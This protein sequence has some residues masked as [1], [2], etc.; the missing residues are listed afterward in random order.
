MLLTELATNLS[1]Y[2][3]ESSGAEDSYHDRCMP[4]YNNANHQN[5]AP[6]H[7]NYRID[8]RQHAYGGGHGHDSGQE[9]A[10]PGQFED[11]SGHRHGPVNSHDGEELDYRGNTVYDAR[12]DM[13]MGHEDSKHGFVHGD[14]RQGR[15]G[16]S[17]HVDPGFNQGEHDWQEEYQ[18]PGFSSFG[19]HYPPH[20]ADPRSHY[21]ESAYHRDLPRNQP[22]P[23]QRNPEFNRSDMRHYSSD[24]PPSKYSNSRRRR[25]S[26]EKK[27][28]L[29]QIKRSRMEGSEHRSSPGSHHSNHQSSSVDYHHP[30]STPE[31]YK[32]PKDTTFGSSKKPLLNRLG[33]FSDEVVDMKPFSDAT[34]SKEVNMLHRLGPMNTVHSRLGPQQESPLLPD[35]RT[36]L[37]GRGKLSAESEGSTSS[38][39]MPVPLFPSSDLPSAKPLLKANSKV[40]LFP[41]SELPSAKS[42]LKV[43]SKEMTPHVP[44]CRS[45]PDGPGTKGTAKAPLVE[46]AKTSTSTVQL[47]AKRPVSISSS[48]APKKII[49]RK[50]KVSQSPVETTPT[51]PSATNITSEHSPSSQNPPNQLLRTSQLQQ[52]GATDNLRKNQ[53]GVGV[54]S[55][56]DRRLP[57]QKQSSI[58]DGQQQSTHGTTPRQQLQQLRAATDP[59]P[60]PSLDPRRHQQ[61]HSLSSTDPRQRQQTRIGDGNRLPTTATVVKDLGMGVQESDSDK[62]SDC[63]L[64]IDEGAC[65]SNDD[66]TVVHPVEPKEH[67][68][69]VTPGVG[70][71]GV[72]DKTRLDKTTLRISA[73]ELDSTLMKQLFAE[74]NLLQRLYDSLKILIRFLNGKDFWHQAF[75]GRIH[76]LFSS[77]SIGSAPSPAKLKDQFKLELIHLKQRCG[78]DVRMWQE[79]IRK[80]SSLSATFPK[81]K[82][83]LDVKGYSD[84]VLVVDKPSG[85]E[86]IV[87]SDDDSSDCAEKRGVPCKIRSKSKLDNVLVVKNMVSNVPV[88][89]SGVPLVVSSMQSV[90][91]TASSTSVPIVTSSVKNVPKGVE[92]SVSS[93]RGVGIREVGIGVAVLNKRQMN[94]PA[95]AVPQPGV[96]GPAPAV[97]QPGVKGPAPAVPQPGVKGPAPAVPQPGV[98]GPAPAVPQPGVKGPTPAVP[99]PGVKG[100]V[101]AVPQPGVKSP[102]PAVPQPGPA[103]AVPQPGVK[104][105]APAVPQPGV[106]CHTSAVTK[107]EAVNVE[108]EQA[109]EVVSEGVSLQQYY[110]DCEGSSGERSMSVCSILSN[111]EMVQQ[112]SSNGALANSEADA[113]DGGAGKD[114]VATSVAIQ[115]RRSV[116]LSSG[117]LTPS[118]PSSPKPKVSTSSR[119]MRTQEQNLPP[120]PSTSHFQDSSRYFLSQKRNRPLQSHSRRP[121]N[122]SSSPSDRHSHNRYRRKSCSRSRERHGPFRRSRSPV[123]KSRQSDPKPVAKNRGRPVSVVK[124]KEQRKKVDEDEDDLELLQLKKEVILSI[125]QKPDM[126][127]P[128][129]GSSL[130]VTSSASVCTSV[131]KEKPKE[132]MQTQTRSSPT[133]TTPACTAPISTTPATATTTAI[134]TAIVSKPKT[135]REKKLNLVAKSLKN[136]NTLPNMKS[137]C[138]S[139]NSSHIGSS[140]GSPVGSPVALLSDAS[141][142]EPQSDTAKPISLKPSTSVKVCFLCGVDV[143]SSALAAGLSRQR[144]HMED[145]AI[146]HHFIRC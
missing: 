85:S 18:D 1:S 54:Q 108:C 131:V 78:S 13:N 48:D 93:G 138:S 145:T 39:I 116:S 84:E 15:Y 46:K 33:P 14:E 139:I 27:D 44:V 144:E 117:E 128:A 10:R 9:Y 64:V 65:S 58:G 112:D 23:V 5:S 75:T 88:V 12:F 66:C 25:E 127:Q 11:F 4:T 3:Q 71:G 2:D 68:K 17:F 57:L 111:D 102:A 51:I 24:A 59:R 123:Q 61:E 106:K 143:I 52:K 45:F 30:R 67:G 55:S 20:H 42:L 22:G 135:V 73:K 31:D 82:G 94:D 72:Y 121:Y 89:V 96:K 35:L 49:V 63:G 98:K 114:E 125:V 110:S 34:E 134:T 104:G 119:V 8:P 56:V 107:L 100:P 126:S 120:K 81:N 146:S 77:F 70:C 132:S 47:S 109:L 74:G 16:S 80:F 6:S 133:S 140:V 124:R 62:E 103:P 105:P 76:H 28:I 53:P 118:P 41:S 38:S 99:Q 79:Q 136:L 115:Q 101:P 95:S 50:L 69:E 86:L 90:V 129:S 122:R 92:V 36:K 142:E 43:N 19:D 26:F 97:P 137:P 83:E 87:I 141:L 113:K 37:S 7:D 21:D 130:D 32:T 29:P 91:S 40:P 60:R